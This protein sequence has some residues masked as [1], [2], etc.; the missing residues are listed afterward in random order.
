MLLDDFHAEPPARPCVEGRK[1]ILV[2][3]FLGYVVSCSLLVPQVHV[4]T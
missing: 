2:S 3:P 1:D 4:G